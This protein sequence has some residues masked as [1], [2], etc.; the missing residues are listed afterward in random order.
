MKKTVLLLM[1]LFASS[2]LVRETLAMDAM[3][4]DMMSETV[5]SAPGPPS[6]PFVQVESS[7]PQERLTKRPKEVSFARGTKPE[8]TMFK[9]PRPRSSETPEQSKQQDVSTSRKRKW[10]HSF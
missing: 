5:T 7:K 4:E 8:E 6:A 9:E 3:D 10:R 2:L 1:L